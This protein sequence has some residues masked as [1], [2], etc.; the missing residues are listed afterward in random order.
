MSYNVYDA[1]CS[2][3]YLAA[4]DGLFYYSVHLAGILSKCL[5][6]SI[7]CVLVTGQALFAGI[8]KFI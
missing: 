1:E 4:R 5:P 2:S 7:L 6:H 3:R 8:S